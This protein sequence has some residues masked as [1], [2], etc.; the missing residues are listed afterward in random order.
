M[1]F[2]VPPACLDTTAIA[3]DSCPSGESLVPYVFVGLGAS[4]RH[5]ALAPRPVSSRAVSGAPMNDN[6]SE[7]ALTYDERVGIGL[8]LGLYLASELVAIDAP[9]APRASDPQPVLFAFLTAG[10]S[11]RVGAVSLAAELAGGVLAYSSGEDGAAEARAR[12]DLWV[13]PWCTLGAVVGTSLI[14]NDEWVTGFEVGIHTH[15]YGA[16]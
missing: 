9:P 1:P 14:R 15:S 8:P 6:T 10:V 2:D 11:Q 13:M 3:D 4:M 12:A 7:S 5:F 16:R